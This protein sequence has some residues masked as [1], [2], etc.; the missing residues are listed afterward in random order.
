M[1]VLSRKMDES[2]LIDGEVEVRLIG[3]RGNRVKL[4]ITAPSHVSVCRKEIAQKYK[5]SKKELVLA[6]V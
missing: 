6:A 2:I 1:L 3:I 4:G 5:Q